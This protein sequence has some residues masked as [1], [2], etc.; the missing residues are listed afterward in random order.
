MKQ[1]LSTVLLVCAAF[2][3]VW[4]QPYMNAQWTN[5]T[6]SSNSF[7][8]DIVLSPGTGY[9]A[10]TTTDG[11][12]FRFDA[13]TG[14]SPLITSVVASNVHSGY[15]A[16]GQTTVPGIPPAGSQEF[17][18]NWSRD[19]TDLL[20]SPGM[21]F[22]LARIT[23]TYAG[24]IPQ[25]A[26]FTLRNYAIGGA[27]GASFWAYGGGQ[28]A[29][30]QAITNTPLPVAITSFTAV[31]EGHT[32]LLSWT[33]ANE[34]NNRDFTVERSADA[35]NFTT[36]GTVA[37]RAPGGTINTALQYSFTDLQPLNGVN[38]YRLKQ[39]DKD[40]KSGCSDVV[41]LSF[42][43]NADIKLYPNPATEVVHVK[44]LEGKNTIRIFNA[45]GQ[46]VIEETTEAAVHPLKVASLA[47]GIYQIQ[48]VRDASVVFTGKF[49][50]DAK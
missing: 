39:T 4:A 45:L 36:I 49:I 38:Y 40:G 16:T 28:T 31:K 46:V 26:S 15:G 20:L 21:P 48:V 7:A 25:S 47:S 8:F 19:A 33:T 23:V 37:T 11:G 3:P 9:S 2:I 5:I 34:R 41:N 35:K 24:A 10:A 14:N 43:K 17:G 12:N 50:K 30:Y 18:I 32:G 44:G 42:D 27:G 29:A 13:S 22:T 1:F 6:Y